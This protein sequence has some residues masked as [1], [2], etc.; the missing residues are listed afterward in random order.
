MDCDRQEPLSQPPQPIA[1]ERNASLRSASFGQQRLWFLNQ[2]EPT[3]PSY[4]VPRVI[5]VEGR[6]NLEV[7]E[8]TLDAIVARHESLRTHFALIDGALMQVIAR[9]RDVGLTLTDLS[10]LPEEQLAVS[11]AHLAAQE[12]RRSFDLAR[13]PL[14][15]AA[16]LRLAVDEHLL[17]LT[18]HHIVSDAWSAGLLFR[19][20]GLLYEA[21]SAGQPS[22]LAPLNFQYADFAAWQRDYLAAGVLEDQLVYWRER[23]ASAPARLDLPTDHAHPSVP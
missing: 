16:V 6:L 23:L 1:E 10:E 21:F 17:L 9:Q 3:S 5:R 11:A 15:R 14:L 18:M 12:G 7:L 22:P 2:L 13:G 8:R 4:N 19:E 20:I